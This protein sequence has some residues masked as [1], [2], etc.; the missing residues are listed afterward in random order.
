MVREDTII[1]VGSNKLISVSYDGGKSFEFKSV[2]KGSYEGYD[3]ID[4]LDD[5]IIFVVIG[6]SFYR[7]TDGGITWLPQ[8]YSHYYYNIYYDTPQIYYFFEDGQGFAKYPVINRNNDS[9]ALV[10]Y[11][12]GENFF[13]TNDL[14]LIVP[15]YNSFS[16]IGLDLGNIVL[17]FVN[18]TKDTAAEVSYSVLRYNKSFKL[19]DSNRVKFNND[20]ISVILTKDSSII[21]LTEKSS[22]TNKADST[23]KTEN[24]SY[25][26]ILLKSTDKGKTWNSLNGNVPFRKKLAK[27]GN[28]DYYYYQ[29]ILYN[30][31]ITHDRFILYPTSDFII[32]S[33]II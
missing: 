31:A 2:F 9:S 19:L 14:N 21:A 15:I 20:L 30:Y 25:K 23:G 17:F 24:Y 13:K 22:G 33:M 28:N 4:I 18:R 3:N 1:A 32:I 26:Y 12:L 27:S 8:H 16:K 5:S 10:T 6:Y 29:S 11:N 7:T